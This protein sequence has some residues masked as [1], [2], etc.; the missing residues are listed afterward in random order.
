[1]A[2]SPQ[3]GKW[4]CLT[5]AVLR[6]TAAAA[7]RQGCSPKT[8]GGPPHFGARTS[9]SENLAESKLCAASEVAPEVV[10]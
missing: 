8:V 6:R 1:M 2:A 10:A 5:D 4:V 3:G 9:L 7:A